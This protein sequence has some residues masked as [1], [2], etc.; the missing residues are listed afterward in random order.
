[1][2]PRW[3]WL[4]TTWFVASLVPVPAVAGSLAERLHHFIDT[5]GFPTFGEFVEVVTPVVERLAVRGIDFPVTA[6][7]PAV[8]Y[9][10]NFDTG[11]FEPAPASLGP[12]AREHLDLQGSADPGEAVGHKADQGPQAQ[13][14]VLLTSLCLFAMHFAQSTWRR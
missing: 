13:G 10:F 1:M 4:A 7:S 14:A 5:R 2:H 11:A 6:T 12:A 8:S 9:R 3:R